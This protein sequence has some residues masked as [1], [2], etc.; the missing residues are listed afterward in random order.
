MLQFLINQVNHQSSHVSNVSTDNSFNNESTDNSSNNESS[1]YLDNLITDSTNTNIINDCGINIDERHLN[2]QRKGKEQTQTNVEQNDSMKLRTDDD[3]QSLSIFSYF[4]LSFGR[5]L[6]DYQRNNFRDSTNLS[7]VASASKESAADVRN[8]IAP[9]EHHT[10]GFGRKVMERMGYSGGGLGKSE[11]GIVSPIKATTIYERSAIDYNKKVPCITFEE[12]IPKHR[13]ANKITPWPANTTLITGSSIISGIEE[14]KL[15]KYKA[16]VR[17][18]PGALIDDMYDN[19]KPLLKRKPSNIFLH[20]GTNDAT[21]KTSDEIIKEIKNL[22]NYIKEVLPNVK[23]F[24]S[25]PVVRFDH[26]Q[27]NFTL[28]RL[29]QKLKSRGDVIINDNVDKSC[30]GKK[31]LHLNAK[32]SGRL[33]TNFISLMRRL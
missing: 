2:S 26:A 13:I 1:I 16:K 18:F 9:W 7:H 23:I 15:K 21:N 20:I 29:D 28:R 17:V 11:N 31:G 6:Y 12:K 32:G 25:C 24:L 5:F 14:S 30:V 22:E 3:A 33:A 8:N 10:T 27:A 19:L 4:Y